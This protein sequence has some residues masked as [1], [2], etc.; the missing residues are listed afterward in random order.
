M[1][2]DPNALKWYRHDVS[3]LVGVYP[4]RLGDND[5]HLKEVKPNA[6]PLLPAL[7]PNRRKNKSGDAPRDKKEEE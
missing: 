4:A 3:G 2:S 1:S 7:I 5:P 6:K